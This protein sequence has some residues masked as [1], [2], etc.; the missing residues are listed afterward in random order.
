MKRICY[1][2]PLMEVIRM[3]QNIILASPPFNS[4]SSADEGFDDSSSISLP[5]ADF[6]SFF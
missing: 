6:G 1:E 2:K 3:D 5:N 4:A